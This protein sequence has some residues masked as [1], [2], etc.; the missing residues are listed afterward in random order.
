L[1]VEFVGTAW[2]PSAKG[3]SVG[4]MCLVLHGDIGHDVAVRDEG[5]ST[6]GALHFIK[7]DHGVIFSVRPNPRSNPK[8]RHGD[9]KQDIVLKE[10]SNE[11]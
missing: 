7:T 9:H 4:K 11:E 1:T 3:C 2:S 8:A 5:E 6:N 10:Q